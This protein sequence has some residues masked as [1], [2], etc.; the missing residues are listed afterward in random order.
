MSLHRFSFY[1]TLNWIVPCFNFVILGQL[2]VIIL[3]SKIFTQYLGHDYS[4]IPM[5]NIKN[6][7]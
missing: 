6:F 2:V 7:T 4:N 1:K 5:T 3:A